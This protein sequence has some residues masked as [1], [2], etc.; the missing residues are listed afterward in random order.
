MPETI[1]KMK[2]FRIAV[3]E[4]MTQSWVKRV[5]LLFCCLCL[6]IRK[7]L[8]I[9]KQEEAFLSRILIIPMGYKIRQKWR[10]YWIM[11][12]GTNRSQR[13]RVKRKWLNA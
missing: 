8:P 3:Y 9:F 2:V 11:L 4:E 12:R 1:I 7:F 6:D 13:I 5:H 10:G